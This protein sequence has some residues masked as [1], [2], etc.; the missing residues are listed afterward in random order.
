MSKLAEH[1]R[2]L[3]S[4]RD[5]PYRPTATIDDKERAELDRK[6][7]SADNYDLLNLREM[8]QAD[9]SN[10][11]F[12]KALV[13]GIA[14]AEFAGIDAFSRKVC[15]WQ[16]WD[17][18]SSLI[19]AIARQTWDEVRHA[20]LATGVLESYG[21]K[22]GEY[23]DTLAGG[24]GGA[25]PPPASQQSTEA[26]AGTAGR[27][28]GGAGLSDPIMMLS[29]VNVS[30]EGGALTLFKETSNLGK[31]IGDPLLERCFDYNWA[32]EVTHTTIGDFFIKL[33]A[34]KNPETEQKALRVHGMSEFGRSRLSG[35]QTEELKEFFAEEMQRAQAALGGNG[36][37]EAGTAAESTGPAGY[38]H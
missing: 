16:D 31:R 5:P 12:R 1:I 28:V 9:P 37:A 25:A 26:P 27:V 8:V 17:V 29:A 33:L 15:E 19:M 22:I 18:P 6:L 13:S 2:Q 23:P 21:G 7:G 38:Q 10:I 32:D 11:E 35:D 3:P 24:A 20:K 34:E 4:R 36:E 14:S 30:L